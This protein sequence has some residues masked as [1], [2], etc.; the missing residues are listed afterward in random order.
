MRKRCDGLSDSECESRVQ[1]A[2]DFTAEAGNR[3]I[4]VFPDTTSAD[5]QQCGQCPDCFK[6][7][8]NQVFKEST[9]YAMASSNF[10]EVDEDGSAKGRFNAW[11]TCWNIGLARPLIGVGPRNLDI[12]ETFER[13][14]PNPRNIHV[15]HE[16]GNAR[17]AQMQPAGDQNVIAPAGVS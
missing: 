9:Q 4:G 10:D 6:P 1:L 11:E 14:S 13:Y 7:A 2:R 16:R 3:Y 17:S 12:P 5:W 15:A 8:F